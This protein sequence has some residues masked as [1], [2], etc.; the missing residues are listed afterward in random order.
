MKSR[1]A[2]VFI[3]ALS[4][5]GA[6]IK[7]VY[8]LA[9][10]GYRYEFPRDHFNHPEFQ[11]EWWYYTGNLHTAE[12]KR[13]G[14]ELTFFRHGV[15]REARPKNVWDVSDIWLAH[16]ALSDVDGNRFFHT[17]RLNRSGPRIA[18]ADFQQARVWNGNWQVLWRLDP[19]KPGGF[20]D[21]KLQAIADEFHIDLV[22][23]SD[24]APVVHGSNGVSQKAEGPGRA[25]HYVSLTRLI[26]RGTI[27]MNGKKFTVEG[28]TWMD[29]EFFTHQ[30]EPNQSGWDWFSLQFEDGSE[31]MLFRL[32]R[33][34][35]SA[36]PYSAGTYIDPQGRTR[37]LNASMFFLSPGKTW[38]S[39]ET[40]ARYPIEWNIR[41]PSLGIDAALSTRLPQQELIG[42]SR[43]SMAYWE[44]AIEIKATRKSQP[45]GGAG[46]LEMTGYAGPVRMGE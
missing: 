28:L 12:G 27:E 16:L 6:D 17:E 29:H 46:Y 18:G 13:F 2:L 11:T 45:L 39:N 8:R 38:T 1:L 40:G 31:M 43:A 22:L 32:R 3:S 36:D 5:F 23:Q 26:T 9:L 33:K 42:K 34:D 37:H 44:G 15:D 21:Q 35:G 19:K 4:V 25:S 7:D 30:L 10:P 14:F 41:V 24:K 20:A